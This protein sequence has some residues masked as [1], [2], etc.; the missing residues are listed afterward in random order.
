MAASYL[1]W[2]APP[3]PWT[4]CGSERLESYRIG[5]CWS[6]PE[7]GQLVDVIE[8]DSS[9]ERIAA[10]GATHLDDVVGVRLLRLAAPRHS[11]FYTAS[12][13]PVRISKTPWLFEGTSS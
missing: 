2:V 4:F 10:S 6:G 11:I 3:A 8:C 7:P 12:A 1:R 5:L 9:A 13:S